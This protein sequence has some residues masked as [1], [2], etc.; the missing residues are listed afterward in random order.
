MQQKT[1]KKPLGQSTVDEA[2]IA[3]FAKLAD[4]WWD[5][6]GPMKPLHQMNPVRLSFIK[7]HTGGLSG[8]SVLD[9][10]CGAGLLSEPMARMGGKVTAID[11]AAKSIEIAKAHAKNEGLSIDYRCTAVEDM[12]EQ[13]DV[14][15]ALEIIEHVADVPAFLD[16][17]S[18]RVKPG[19]TLFISTL[20]RTAKS[21]LMAIVGAE[22][23][24]QILPKGTHDW[25]KFL[26]PSEVVIPTEKRGFK[27]KELKGMFFHPLSKTWSLSDRTDVNYIVCFTKLI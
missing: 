22:Y 26:T 18:A 10:G 11:A 17:L 4:T 8:K 19:G 9:V 12:T 6:N 23:V 3:Q 27:L 1:N 16:A 14:V 7:D 15:T 5:A 21:Y 13:F 20:N 2:E 25:K 24:L